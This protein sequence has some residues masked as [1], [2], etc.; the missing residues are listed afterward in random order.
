MSKEIKNNRLLWQSDLE[1]GSYRNPILHADYSDPDVIRVGDTYYMTASSFNYMPGLPIL[2]SKDLVNWELVNY[3]VKELPYE[4][5]KKPAHAKG[6]W[7]PSIRFHDNKFWIF[8]GMPDEG[9]FMTCAKDPLKE[10]EPMVCVWEGKG[11]IDPCPY[12]DEDGRAYVV[13]AYA[14]SRIGIKSKLAIFEMNPEGTKCISEDQV[15]FDGTATQ[16]TIEGPKV[17]KRDGYYYIFAPAGGVKPGWQTVL[18][19]TSIYGPYEEKIVM[20]QGDSIINGPHQGGLV[21]TPNG[22]EWFLHFQQKG[23]Y[24]RI[25]HLQPVAWKNGWPMI[26][27]DT[28]GDGIGEPVLEYKKPE[29]ATSTKICEPA[30]SDN[31][32]S[33]QLGLQW[34]WLANYSDSFYSL[35][36]EKGRLCLYPLNTTGDSKA[37]LWNCANVLTQKIVCPAFTAVTRMDIT[38]LPVGARSGMIMIGARY[39]A[40]YVEKTEEALKAVYVEAQGEG[41]DLKEEVIKEYDLKAEKILYLKTRF[42]EDQTSEFLFSTDGE[43]WSEPTK[44]FNPEGAT[45]VGAK[46]G[47]FAVSDKDYLEGSKVFFDYFDMKAEIN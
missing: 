34:Q 28:N 38:V 33:S 5:Y 45:W 29:G 17:Y 9:I 40:L 37:L 18:R 16:P 12:W 44:R 4:V 14:N 41:K 25:A 30:T 10:W 46:I 7:A 43:T 21:D 3:A 2:T 15:I 11:F 22:E 36:E 1:N 23:A 31:F 8:V 24:G 42:Y 20:H 35:T 32:E 27:I 47:I 6:I 39:S 19:S 13:H 26:G